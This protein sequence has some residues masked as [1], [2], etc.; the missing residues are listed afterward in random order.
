MKK[1]KQYKYIVIVVSLI[2]LGGAFYSLN[3]KTEQEPKMVE[4]EIVN[5]DKIVEDIKCPEPKDLTKTEEVSKFGGVNFF[6]NNVSQCPS[7]TSTSDRFGCLYK[8]AEATEKEASTLAE[9]LISQAPI[10]LEEIKT[11]KTGPVPFVYGG[12]DFLTTLPVQVSKA[13]QVKDEYIR[14]VCNLTSMTIYGGSGMDLEQNACKYYFNN[15]YLQI[16][17]SL[18]E[19]LTVIE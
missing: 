13:Q 14:S 9:K 10:H 5:S 7:N 19:G 12:A 1:I 6:M 15:E 8:L 18:E 16:L 2:I 4:T 11:E 3:F 17:R